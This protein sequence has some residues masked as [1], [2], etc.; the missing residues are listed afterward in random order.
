MLKIIEVPKRFAPRLPFA[1]PPH[2]I[3]KIMIE[4]KCMNYFKK[5]CNKIS[6]EYIYL[7]I[8]WTA[9]HL[10]N[11]YGKNLED[12]IDYYETTIKKFP[13]SNFFTIVQYDGGTL[14]KLKNCRI[15]SCSGDFMS[16]IGENSYYEPIP[17]IC[18]KH[19][20]KN[21]S[22][23][24]Y[25]V[26]FCGRK[27][28]GIREKI[29]L[30]LKNENDYFLHETISNKFTDI[31]TQIFRY[32]INNSIFT[33]CPRGYGP[34]SF[35]LYES[36]QMKSIPIYISDKFWLP[37]ENEI[38]WSKFALCINENQINNIP[39]I[40]DNIIK[41][42]KYEEMIKEGQRIYEKYFTWE[43]IIKNIVKNIEA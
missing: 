18:D 9:Y 41:E 21:I 11:G 19:P 35:R 24:K 26:T 8:Q 7:P 16:P 22:N 1:Y 10:L 34:T 42:K 28:H 14:I 5:N 40:V 2:Q 23:K 27:T 15:F 33:L 30:T 38:K 29:F 43:S 36:I 31:D 39:Q 37:Y 6:S 4:E 13:K 20:I 3:D 32:L 12:L 17:L 25:K